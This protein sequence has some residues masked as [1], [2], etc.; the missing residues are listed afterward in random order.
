MPETTLDARVRR[1]LDR[2]EIADCLV[3]YTRGADRLDVELFHS[4]FHPGALD[5]RGGGS[6]SP[7][8][9][10]DGWLPKQPERD[11]TQHFL[12]NHTIEIDGDVAHVESY[13]LV[14]VK[15]K[16]SGTISLHSGR[17]VDR[18][19][20]RDGVWAIAVRVVVPEWHG[21]VTAA[22]ASP[23]LARSDWGRRSSDDPSYERP[24]QAR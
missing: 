21:L 16:T 1:L 6:L 17:Y 19:E 10:L 22:S 15:L 3:R 8:E 23:V 2:E 5:C 12:S 11:V 4:A 14:A 18:F 24:L 7:Q 9:F 13:H 20:K